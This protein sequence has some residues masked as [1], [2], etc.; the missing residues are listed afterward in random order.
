MSLSKFEL[1]HG[2]VLLQIIRNPAVNIKL[3]DKSD[4][5]EWSSYEVISKN[6]THKVFVKS[7][8]KVSISKSKSPYYYAGFSFS[9]SDINRLRK[10][11]EDRNLLICLVCADKEICT[12]NWSDIDELRL[13]FIK[14]SASIRISWT[15][16]S[17]LRI[18]CRGKELESTVP[19]NR[20]KMYNWVN[21]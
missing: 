15:N 3:I 18:K 10:I 21:V 4:D 12:L 8:S 11:N 19:R 9:I 17:R 2:A 6:T 13:L 16:G 5:L 14:E 7:T 1:Y 20:L